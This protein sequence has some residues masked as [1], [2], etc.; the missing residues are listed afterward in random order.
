MDT[1]TE[2]IEEMTRLR[3]TADRMIRHIEAGEYDAAYSCGA[4]LCYINITGT[5]QQI[6]ELMEGADR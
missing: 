5:E 2:L 6:Q 4:A 1:K 3:D